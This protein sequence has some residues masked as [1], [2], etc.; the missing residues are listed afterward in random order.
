[1]PAQVRCATSRTVRLS[2]AVRASERL[3]AVAVL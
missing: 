2:P 1:M 3:P